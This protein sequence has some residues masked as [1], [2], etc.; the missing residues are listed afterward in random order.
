[1]LLTHAPSSISLSSAN[2]VDDATS[3]TKIPFCINGN[4]TISLFKSLWILMKKKS[5]IN[6]VCLYV[7]SWSSEGKD[8]PKI[9]NKRESYAALQPGVCVD[10]FQGSSVDRVSLFAM[11]LWS[12]AAVA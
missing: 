5:W 7:G 8:C 4:I 3:Q 10:S 6:D 2:A 9:S 1:M 11:M 12:H